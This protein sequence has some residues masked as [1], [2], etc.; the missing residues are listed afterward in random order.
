VIKTLNKYLT[1][2]IGVYK[3]EILDKKKELKAPFAPVS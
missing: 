2:K 3:K 1:R